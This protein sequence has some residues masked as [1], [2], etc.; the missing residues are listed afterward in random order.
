MPASV[1]ASSRDLAWLDT[2]RI[3]TRRLIAAMPDAAPPYVDEED[4]R[5]R[6]LCW[7]DTL[8]RVY[9]PSL[10]KRFDLV[11]PE[12]YAVDLDAVRRLRRTLAGCQR[13]AHIVDI[14]SR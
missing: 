9:S 1:A 6:A 8:V 12:D 5:R 4:F 10:P 2:F 7:R 11:V 13:G 14:G 3:E